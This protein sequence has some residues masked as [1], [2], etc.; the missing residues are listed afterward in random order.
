KSIVPALTGRPVTNRS[1]ICARPAA[2]PAA[3][4]G[5]SR[6][7]PGD[8]DR[9]AVGSIPVPCAWLL[10]LSSNVGQA[11]PTDSTRLHPHNP[12]PTWDGSS[13]AGAGG[14]AVFFSERGRIGAGQVS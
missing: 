1:H 6:R 2:A 9:L 10:P 7:G 14:R 13:P 11:G 8:R 5:H 3:A 4:A 12:G